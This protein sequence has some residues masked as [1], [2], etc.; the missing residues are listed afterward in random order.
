MSVIPR[1]AM[2][3][4]LPV[5]LYGFADGSPDRQS[6]QTFPLA[7]QGKPVATI[8]IAKEPTAAA[9]FAAAE[10]KYHIRKI[11][12]ATLPVVTDEAPVSGPRILVGESDATRAI[13][14]RSDSFKPLERLVRFSKDTLILMGRDQ[15]RATSA[16]AKSNPTWVPAKFGHGFQF[17]G[18]HNVI[19]VAESGLDDEVGTIE[20]WV[21]LPKEPSEKHGTI[22][23]WD[24]G[25]P[26]SYHILQREAKTNRLS[27]WVYNTKTGRQLI[28]GDLTEGWH[29]IMATH[30]VRDNK[31]ELFVD[32]KSCGAQD[33]PL[34]QCKAAVLYIGAAGAP[35]ADGTLGNPLNGIVDEV[36]ISKTVRKP[37]A[38]GAGG[39]YSPDADTALLLHFDEPGGGLRDAA[40]NDLSLNTPGSFEARGT[41]DAVYDFLEKYCDV[42]WYAPGELGLVCPK[43]PT[44]S[45]TPGPEIRRRPQ[46]T[47]RWLAGAYLYMPT[48]KDPVNGRDANLWR[49]RMRLGGYPFTTVGHSFYGY[50]DRFLKD[51][52]DWFAQG[53]SGQPPQM[54]YTNPEFI[55]QVVQD[56]R[57]YFDGKGAK[58]GAAATGDFFG[59]VPMDNGS[60]CKCPRCLAEMNKAEEK[61]PQF[62]NGKASDYIY[63]FVNK[64]AREVRKTHP[65]KWIAELAYSDYAYYP[66]KVGLEPNVSVQMCLH[67]RNWWC[68]S[69]EQNDVKMLADWSKREKGKRPLQ[70]WLYYC[71][72][73]LNATSGN[74]N[75]FPGFF[76]HQVPGQMKLYHEAGI[77]GMY[78][79]NSS[80]CGVTYLM[81]QLEYYVTLKLAD[82]PTLN[83]NK[84]IEEFFTRYYGAAA[85]PMKQLY[86]RIEDTFTN[87]KYYPVE[88]QKSPAHQHQNED[89]AWGSLGTEQRMAEFEKLMSQA[90]QAARTPEEKQR[91]ALFEKG[92]W[93]YMVEGRTKFLEHKKLRAQPVPQVRVPRLATAADGDVTKVDWSQAANL[94]KWGSL[95]GDSTDRKIESRIA[96]DG[97]YFYVQLTEQTNPARLASGGQVW[98]GEDWEVFFAAQ[99]AKPYRQICIAPNGKHLE[100]AWDEAGSGAWDSGIRVISDISSHDQWTVRCALPFTKIVP[101]GLKPGAKLYCNLYRGSPSGL[102]R[103]AWVPT[104]STGFHDVSRLAE[105]V[106][107]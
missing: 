51:H 22:V 12:G 48:A 106:M 91:I 58:P 72:P 29:H 45:V 95:S 75:A 90:R 74:Y 73:A 50:Y 99:R 97:S 32:G 76:A 11:T 83:G 20:A 30:S 4:L 69:M 98:D 9:E 16:A 64:V 38:D 66:T 88:I 103:L 62:N 89:L 102:D 27:Y 8:V 44:L 28:S 13:G 52:P 107:Q 82:D 105:L 78:I 92:I 40:G 18:M 101:G 63:N 35:N 49:M 94:G 1:Y 14:L 55:Q 6:S 5:L 17:D 10:L 87:P 54:C 60:Y 86:N 46:I 26:W 67:T 71:F 15:S 43:T 56:A 85:K 70:L 81:D 59:L 7:A 42:R 79:E 77:S 53:Y 104:F 80:E 96:H 37:E 23:R 2:A 19:T 93:D 34:T 41:A 36:R 31:I 84:L 100:L 33:Y 57:D 24:G 39:P 68:P 3:L 21:W 61:N 65:N 25:G 47:H